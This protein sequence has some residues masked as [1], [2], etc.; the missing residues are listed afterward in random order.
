LFELIKPT[1]LDI[2]DAAY[3]QVVHFLENATSRQ[4]TRSVQDILVNAPKNN[5]SPLRAG[6]YGKWTKH[7][8]LRRRQ[9]KKGNSGLEG[10]RVRA[11]RAL[12]SLRS[13]THLAAETRWEIH[14]PG[15]EEREKL[16]KDY[17]ERK[18][19]VTRER[20]QDAETVIMQQQEHMGNVEK[21]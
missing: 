1:N 7:S 9:V 18:T 16:I 8:T 4:S 6:I 21:E 17:V 2:K 3:L 5:L 20:V 10:D 15:N 11:L 13:K 14:F 19:A 12:R